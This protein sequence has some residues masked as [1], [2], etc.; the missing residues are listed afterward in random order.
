MSSQHG[1]IFAASQHWVRDDIRTYAAA[2]EDDGGVIALF[3]TTEG[4]L[5][6]QTN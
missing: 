2:V 4:A 5:P 3:S 1:L 6:A